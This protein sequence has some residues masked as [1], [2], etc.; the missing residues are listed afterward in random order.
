MDY[1][2]QFH[3][4]AADVRSI[5]YWIELL[6]FQ[7]RDLRG[8]GL[9][10][11]L[12]ECLSLFSSNPC[13]FPPSPCFCR[14]ICSIIKWRGSLQA[15]HFVRGRCWIGSDWVSWGQIVYVCTKNVTNV[16]LPTLKRKVVF[17]Y[18]KDSDKWQCKS[19]PMWI[20]LSQFLAER[21]HTTYKKY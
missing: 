11:P 8:K 2:T 14:H 19:Y 9:D 3:P 17:A 21:T 7:V 5:I 1:G 20:K 18:S 10:I 12:V 13:Y 16:M 6:I 15:W 4:R